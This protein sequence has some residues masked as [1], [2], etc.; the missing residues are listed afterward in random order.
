MTVIAL[1]L[2]EGATITHRN[3][4]EGHMLRLEQGDLF[5]ALNLD[6]ATCA[7]LRQ[8]ILA[9]PF[10]ELRQRDIDGRASD[11][12]E[13]S[14]PAWPRRVTEALDQID[15]DTASEALLD[16]YFAHIGATKEE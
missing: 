15:S 5:L 2:T 1:R 16:N 3:D 12:I 4:D 9:D 7:R 10:E 8:I 13:G 6:D 11:D 14:A